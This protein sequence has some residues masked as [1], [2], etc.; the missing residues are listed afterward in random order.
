MSFGVGF[1]HNVSDPPSTEKPT[2]EKETKQT[3]ER[4]AGKIKFLS[5]EAA[6][7]RSTF[8]VIGLSKEDPH[9]EEC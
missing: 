2:E 4:R 1:I 3:R 5:F 8:S 6:L 9:V 7:V